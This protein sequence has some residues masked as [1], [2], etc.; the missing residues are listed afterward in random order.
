MNFE[1][2]T[3]YAKPSELELFTGNILLNAAFHGDIRSVLTILNTKG[4]DVNY[5]NA[6]GVTVLQLATMRGHND[7]V[8]VL[9]ESGADVDRV[10]KANRTALHFAYLYNRPAI[11]RL[12]LSYGAD[13]DLVS[14]SSKAYAWIV[15]IQCVHS[16]N[17]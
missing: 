5:S 9:L 13:V 15:S 12:L 7:V 2:G 3:T 11:A 17:C 6:N 8:G 1:A 14:S 10:D 4:V 16:H